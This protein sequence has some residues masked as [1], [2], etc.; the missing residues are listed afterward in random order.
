MRSIRIHAAAAAVML[1]VTAAQADD[2]TGVWVSPR[3]DTGSFLELELSPCGE[4]VC[5]V[6]VAV[7]DG[8]DPANVGKQM[9]WDMVLGDDGVYSDGEVWAPDDDKVYVG[10]MRLIDADTLGLSGCVLGG[11]ICRESAFVRK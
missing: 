4:A 1:T 11:L 9:V 8:G 2:I 3:S 5:G 10:E 7:H 6:I